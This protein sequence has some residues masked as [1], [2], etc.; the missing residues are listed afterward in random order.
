MVCTYTNKLFVVYL[1]LNFTG[2]P[3]FYLLD[4]ATLPEVT[5]RAIARWADL[6]DWRDLRECH[7]WV[8]RAEGEQWLL[9]TWE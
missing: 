3:Y 2:L 5:G 6:R 1:K 7:P 8:Y 4:L 9:L